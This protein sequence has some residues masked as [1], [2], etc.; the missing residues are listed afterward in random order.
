MCAGCGA[1][2]FSVEDT[3]EAIGLMGNAGIKAS[4]ASTSMRSIAGNQLTGDV[5][6][7]EI[8][9]Q[10][11]TIATYHECGRFHAGLSAILADCRGALGMTEAEG[12]ANNE[13]VGK[14]AMSGVPC[15]D[16][17]GRNLLKVSGAVNNCKGCGKHSGG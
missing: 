2:G 17:C 1:L 4:Q 13:L 11:V 16:E 15:T 8:G 12:C 3:A 7:S 6:L 10:D 9:D 14:N 5:K